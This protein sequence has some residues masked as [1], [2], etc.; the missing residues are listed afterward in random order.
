MSK[1]RSRC[2]LEKERTKKKKKSL[3][4]PKNELLFCATHQVTGKPF[5][6]PSAAALQHRSSTSRL[7][8]EGHQA[9]SHSL[10]SHRPWGCAK[11]N[12]PKKKTV[13]KHQNF[14]NLSGITK[15]SLMRW[16]FR[17][18]DIEY[19]V[20]RCISRHLRVTRGHMTSDL[21]TVLSQKSQILIRAQTY[22]LRF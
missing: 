1:R 15:K 17:R 6:F 5:S 12:N 8:A 20:S 16:F 11:P 10:R 21:V 9:G 18:V 14:K 7:L 13:I 22:R 4:K 2:F 3:A 19:K